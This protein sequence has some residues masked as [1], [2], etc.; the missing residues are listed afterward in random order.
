MRNRKQKGLIVRIGDR[1]FVRYWER[2]SVRG[3]IERKRVSHCL[4]P[5]TSRG[6]R[7]PA[8]IVLEAERHMV[9]VNSGVF[10]AERI[11][12]VSDYVELVY[13][14]WIVE[15][16]RPST[17]KGYKDIWEL[18]LQALAGTK[19]LKDVRTHHVQGW[20][21]ELAKRK[22]SRNTLKHIK[23][24]VSAI[25]TLRSNS[26]TFRARIRHATRRLAPHPLS[27]RKPTRT[28]WRRFTRYWPVCRSLLRRHSPWPPSRDCAMARS[29]AYV[30]RITTTGRFM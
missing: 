14:P 7:R 23:S 1:W 17:V 3:S 26:T 27:R 30:G 24:V 18:H 20:L 10:T 12:T 19:W 15:H 6:K 21:N 25:F 9:D 5:V 4:G 8:D 28:V 29:R 2:R 16:K 11:V 13:L 22:L